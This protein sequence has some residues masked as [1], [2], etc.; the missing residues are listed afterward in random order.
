M[1]SSIETLNDYE[2][3][4]VAGGPLSLFARVVIAA[5]GAAAVSDAAKSIIEVGEKIHDALCAH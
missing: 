2:I 3:D 1:N 4:F 5:G